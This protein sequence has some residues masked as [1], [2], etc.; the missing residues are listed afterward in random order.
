MKLMPASV[1]II[2]LFLGFCSGWLGRTVNIENH[3][4]PDVHEVQWHEEE[5]PPGACVVTRDD[6]GRLSGSER[7]DSKLNSLHK[8]FGGPTQR[9]VYC[10]PLEGQKATLDGPTHDAHTTV[11]TIPTQPTPVPSNT[12]QPGITTGTVI[13]FGTR[14]DTYVYRDGDKSYLYTNGVCTIQKAP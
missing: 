10:P 5:P 4:C 12:V 14:I 11:I 3:H 7:W 9:W 6:Y 13:N 2:G 1:V 8:Y